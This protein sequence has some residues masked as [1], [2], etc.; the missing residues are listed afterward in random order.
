MLHELMGE[1]RRMG[2]EPTIA[3]QTTNSPTNLKLREVQAPSAGY[4]K[5][6]FVHYRFNVDKAVLDAVLKQTRERDELDFESGLLRHLRQLK[7]RFSFRKFGERIHDVDIAFTPRDRN[8]KEKRAITVA[9]KY[10]N[11]NQAWRDILKARTNGSIFPHDE[12]AVSFN[13]AESKIRS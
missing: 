2:L 11:L 4:Q 5:G 10:K 12:L 8:Q 13:H 1:V 3:F 6:V 7:P 9:I